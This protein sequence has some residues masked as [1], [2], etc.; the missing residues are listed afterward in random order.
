MQLLS[1]RCRECLLELG[2]LA[3]L[4]EAAMEE[5]GTQREESRENVPIPEALFPLQS[6]LGR[7]EC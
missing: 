6:D 2:G 5:P 1:L 7:N 4:N 3:L